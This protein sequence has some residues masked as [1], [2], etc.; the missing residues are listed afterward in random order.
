MKDSRVIPLRSLRSLPAREWE[1][2]ALMRTMTE[3]MG[4]YL[5]VLIERRRCKQPRALPPSRTDTAQET[6]LHRA[7]ES[8]LDLRLQRAAEIGENVLRACDKARARAIAANKARAMMLL[9]LV[10][11]AACAD[12]AAGHSKRWR[13]GRVQNRLQGV[14]C[15][16][17]RHVRNLLTQ[18]ARNGSISVK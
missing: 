13:A 17:E 4:A 14:V 8:I 18:L 15:V 7:P 9:D 11:R 3:L 2:A 5:D 12:E 1:R 6:R 16:T 10:Q